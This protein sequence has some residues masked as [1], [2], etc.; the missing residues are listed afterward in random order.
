M[1]EVCRNAGYLYVTATM[2]AGA[3]FFACIVFIFGIYVGSEF[4]K[5]SPQQQEIPAVAPDPDI[6]RSNDRIRRLTVFVPDMHPEI[7][8]NCEFDD[9]EGA[10]EP[11][12]VS[13]VKDGK[14]IDFTGMPYRIDWED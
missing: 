9:F 11:P 5:E 6:N 13:V 4:S 8:E 3:V 12:Y 7:V 1:D 10:G 14:S 2:M